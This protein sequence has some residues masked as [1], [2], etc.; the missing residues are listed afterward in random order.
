MADGNR[1]PQ[2]QLVESTTVRTSR[3][4]EV[5]I[6]QLVDPGGIGSQTKDLSGTLCCH[7]IV[8][9]CQSVVDIAMIW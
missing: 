5:P 2:S 8:N 1:E 4:L 7:P 9:A 3:G 6:A